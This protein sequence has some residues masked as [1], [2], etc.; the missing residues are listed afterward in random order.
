MR[1][2]RA[3]TLNESDRLARDEETVRRGFWRK[4]GALAARIPFAEDL[5]TAYYCAFDRRTPN[6]VRAAL[7]GALAYFVL[8]FDALPDFLPLLGLTDDAAVLAGALRLVWTHIAPEHRAAARDTLAH[9]NTE[10]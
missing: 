9:L 10:S 2:A 3:S 7:I 6:H 4:L 1:F 8:P 5:L